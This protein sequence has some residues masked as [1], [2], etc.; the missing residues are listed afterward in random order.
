MMSTDSLLETFPE[1]FCVFF[2]TFA[3]WML[4]GYQQMLLKI[5]DTDGKFG[6]THTFSLHT[7]IERHSDSQTD[8]QTDP[9]KDRCT[10]RLLDG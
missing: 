1:I 7:Y 2:V 6:N 4:D 5:E 8:R 3:W 10:D 9:W